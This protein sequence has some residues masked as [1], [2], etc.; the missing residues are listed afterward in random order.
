MNNF[1]KNLTMVIVMIII[2]LIFS[3]ANTAYPIGG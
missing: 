3:I 1:I 2:I